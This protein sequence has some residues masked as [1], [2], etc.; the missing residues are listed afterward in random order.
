MCSLAGT[1]N[2][3]ST[4]LP[5]GKGGVVLKVLGVVPWRHHFALPF[6]VERDDMDHVQMVNNRNM[7]IASLLLL[8]LGIMPAYADG[9]GIEEETK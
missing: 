6:G 5:S 4:V 1:G 8:S 7:L 2:T 3:H 9:A